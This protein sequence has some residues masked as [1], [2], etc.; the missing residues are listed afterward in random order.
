[1]VG[2]YPL[3]WPQGYPRTKYPGRSRFDN[4]F[5]SARDGIIAEIKLMGGKLPIISTNIELRRDGLPYSGQKQ[6]QDKGVAV[7]FTYKNE[8]VVFACDKWD[9][10]EH[11]LHA[12]RKTIDAMRGVERWGV[13]DLLNRAFV[14][15]KALPES[16]AVDL[17]VPDPQTCWDILLLQP[18][19]S[20]DI[21][22]RSYKALRKL[23]HPDN[24]LTGN[25]EK[26][27]ALEPAYN[28]ALKLV[29]K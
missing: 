14:G 28:E 5:A 10:I 3:H 24:L 6:P 21:I 23:Y 7:Y 20:K 4:T 29:E 15:F 17:D 25:H 16:G 1:M 12:I 19:A 11:N 22:E 18:F 9:K 2:A 27:V 8:Q 13:S 26:F